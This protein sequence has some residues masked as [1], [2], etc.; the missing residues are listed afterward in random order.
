MTVRRRAAGF[1]VIVSLVA[2]A[3]CT[4]NDKNAPRAESPTSTPTPDRSKVPLPPPVKVRQTPQGVEL[5]DPK[6]TP[7]PGARADFGR[8]GG[9]VYQIEMPRHWNGRLLLYMHGFEELGTT[10]RVTAPDFRRYLIGHGYAWGASSFSSTGL[11]PGRSADE[12]AALWDFFARKYGRPHYT[13]VSG[14][15]MG[16]MS[17]HLAAERYANRFDGALALCGSASQT[18]AVSGSADL[19]AAAA[20]AV[21]LTQ[22]DFDAATNMHALIHDGILP[23]LR[24][25]DAH[26][27]FVDIMIALT[28]GPRAFDRQGFEVEEQTNWRRAELTVTA[29]IAPNRDTKYH[30]GPPSTVTSA[31]FNRAVIRLPI[32]RKALHDFVAGNDT[33][34]RLRMPL[35]SLH[36]TGDGQVPIEQAR[37]LQRRVDAAGKSAL[38]VQ[39]VMRDASHC[40]F[41]TPEQAAS[42]EALVRWV[43]HGVKP[44][45]TNVLTSDLRKL[46]RTFELL[47]RLGSGAGAVPGAADRVTV[48]GNAT[49]DG[50]A[51][52]AR[53]LGA[54]VRR[55]G[56]VTAC[57]GG[58]PPVNRG[59][60]EIS[61][62]AAAEGSGCGAPG[63]QVAVWAFVNNAML[64]STNTLAWPANGKTA[65]FDARFSTATPQGAVPLTA[66]FE[67]EMFRSDGRQ[68]PAGT[69]VEAYVGD[70]RCGVASTRY[71]D[72][73][74]GY[75][76][77]VVGPDA[78]T[79]CT[80][81]AT[82]TFRVDGLPALETAVN[83]PPGRRGALDL[84]VP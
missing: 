29:Q 84:T 22:A 20:Y 36:T 44:T 43:E 76:L 8:L 7:I 80:R 34:G 13:Y 57:Q 24:V 12:T 11:I 10:A 2:V 61:V 56:L 73:F 6:F 74:A 4:G 33:S 50:K 71:S 58:L 14:L 35:I 52:D 46:D 21:G 30:L 18:P 63:A 26:R 1:A 9:T 83:Q 66:V 5:G 45:G 38:L 62:L 69:R 59:R 16:G 42:F 37:I 49:L 48:R 82:V 15:S 39:R 23:A 47:P 81:G 40:G 70:H 32:N 54:V 28:G 27:R 25:P 75:I 19:F 60:F 51:F 3:A 55:N 72:N 79:G 65:T 53:F 41:T 78:I 77:N 31:E 67:G 68:F 17:T 64:Y